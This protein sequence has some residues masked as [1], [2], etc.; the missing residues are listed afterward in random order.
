MRIPVTLLAVMLMLVGCGGGKQVDRI[1]TETTTDLSGEWNDTDS[2]LVA[3]EMVE[4][5]L[6]RPW[7]NDFAAAVSR[8]P[9]V[10]VGRIRNRSSDHIDTE[11]FTKDF[12]RQLLNSGTIRFVG[13]REERIDVRDEREDQ[14]RHASMETMKRMAQE[15][16]ADLLLVG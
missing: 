4:D 10:T 14:Q 5:C 7:L 11:T 3:Q 2:R 12:E 13:S 6:A 8:K 1:G 15:V 16:G 9:V